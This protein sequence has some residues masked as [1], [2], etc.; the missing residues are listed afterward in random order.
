V[1]RYVVDASIAVKWFIPET[2]SQSASSFQYTSYG[3]HVPAFFMLE[4][5]NVLS[6]KIRRGELTPDEG[7][8]ILK[9][10]R[11]LPL[12]YHDDARLFKPACALALQTQRSLYDCLY[13][14]LSEVIDGTLVT[15]DRKF[16]MA[17]A[18]GTYAN[19]ILWVEEL[20]ERR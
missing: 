5:G 4:L 8:I 7:E 18:Y 14:A 1:K 10:V 17:L 13:L 12:Q 11:R 16:Y 15:A 19:R 6:K 9:E 2:H 3:L 20:A